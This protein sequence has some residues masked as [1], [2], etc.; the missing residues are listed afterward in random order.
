MSYFVR[1]S[2]DELRGVEEEI[3]TLKEFVGIMEERA[4]ALSRER[5]GIEREIKEKR[6]RLDDRK[7]ELEAKAAEAVKRHGLLGLRRIAFLSGSQL[8][9]ETKKETILGVDYLYP[10]VYVEPRYSLTLSSLVVDDLADFSERFLDDLLAVAKFV[11]AERWLTRELK[12][13]R[14][15]LNAI[16]NLVLPE[17]KEKRKKIKKYLEEKERD[18]WVKRKQVIESVERG[19]RGNHI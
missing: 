18:N 5:T 15:K 19:S 8:E 13:V 1:P 11:E 12:M 10:S 2:K 16:S 6:A 14:R 3:E 7:K 4:A 9:V 17:L